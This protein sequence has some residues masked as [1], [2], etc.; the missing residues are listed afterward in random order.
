MFYPLESNKAGAYL[1]RGSRWVAALGLMW[2]VIFCCFLVVGCDGADA[3]QS[4]ET[5]K[6]PQVQ[7]T[8]IVTLAPALSQIFVDLNLSDLLVGVS[9]HDAFA[10]AGLPVVGNYLAPNYEAILACKPTHVLMLWGKE[11]VPQK[12]LDLGRS[13]HFKVITWETPHTIKD[14]GNLIYNAKDAEGVTLHNSFYPNHMIYTLKFKFLKNL[15]DISEVLPF[16]SSKAERPRV[17]MVIGLNPLMISAPGGTDT[18]LNDLLVNKLNATNAG[19]KYRVSAP[20]LTGEDLLEIKPDVVLILSSQIGVPKSIAEANRA[21][22]EYPP[23]QLDLADYPRLKVFRGLDIPAVKNGRIY[24]ITD[25]R[26]VL[27]ATSLDH[28]AKQMA[29][30]IYPE[31]AAA[32]LKINTEKIK[33]I[34]EKNDESQDPE[35]VPDAKK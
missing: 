23:L 15:L 10:P 26:A 27:P 25:P 11:G 6:T 3:P 28:L 18:V 30:A 14:I 2:L 9:E 12:L 17:L 29:V 19:E 21:S 16:T 34:K 1:A 22:G 5:V 24:L 32:L 35:A 13:E 31:H 7:T 33:P 8:R 4:V 20:V